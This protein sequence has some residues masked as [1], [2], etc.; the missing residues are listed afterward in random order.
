MFHVDD[1]ELDERHQYNK[2]QLPLRLVKKY[3]FP[4]RCG[5][6]DNQKLE[7]TYGFSSR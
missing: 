5:D 2:H 7:I 4:Y 6:F 3:F 1:M